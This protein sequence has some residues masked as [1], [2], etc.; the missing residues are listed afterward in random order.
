MP[1]LGLGTYL[2]HGEQARRAASWALEAGYRLIDTALAYGNEP[3]IGAALR[4]SGLSREQVFIASKL[5]NQ[6]H[7]YASTLAACARS[8]DNLATDYLDLYLIHWPVPGLRGETWRAMER[9]HAEGRCRAVGVSNYTVRHLT[10]LL[11][12]SQ[13][14]PAVNQVE[15]HPFLYQRELFAFCRARGIV[16]EAYSPLVKGQRFDHPVIS[17][18]ATRHG[19]SPAQVLLRWHLQ[20]GLV[21]IPKSVHRSYIRENARIWD[22]ALSDQDMARLDALDQGRHVDWDPSDLP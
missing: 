5:E 7:G 4:A 16:V 6:D 12:D 21:A 9:L 13:Q 19:R 20:H 14:V 18:I 8:L 3:Q 11:R 2:A 10:E 17:R 15:F 22:F 1:R